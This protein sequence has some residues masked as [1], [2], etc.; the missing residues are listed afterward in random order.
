MAITLSD[1]FQAVC[2]VNRV[3]FAWQAIPELLRYGLTVISA[4]RTVSAIH[5][6]ART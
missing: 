3:S 2:P 5:F 1:Y 6:D 4:V